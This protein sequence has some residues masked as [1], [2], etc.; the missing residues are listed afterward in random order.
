MIRTYPVSLVLKDKRAVVVGGGSVAT[1][2]V[3]GLLECEA[4]VS[5]VAPAASTT[6][7]QLADGV[8]CTWRAKTYE[9]ADLDEA[10]IVFA[11][12]DDEV[13]NRRVYDDAT[14]ARLMVNV[15]DRPEVCT[16]FLPS[17]LRRGKLSI[18]VSTEGASP[19]TARRIREDMEERYGQEY[20]DY[21]ELLASWRPRVSA[22]LPPERHFAFWEQASDGRVL[23]LMAEG[24]AGEAEAVLESLLS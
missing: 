12:T 1:R 4:F 24:R 21:L 17:V 15:A 6:L 9:T 7:R 18:A 20:G 5:V 14:A 2:K 3:L 8:R 22:A 13:A 23:A 16:F 10:D 19:F 11:A